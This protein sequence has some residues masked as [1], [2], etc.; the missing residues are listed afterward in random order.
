MHWEDAL[1]LSRNRGP[2]PGAQCREVL[3]DSLGI[4]VVDFRCRIP[5]HAEGPEEPNLTHSIA[6]VRRG[7]FRRSWRR[8]TL[9]ADANYVLF[10]N[11][12]EPYRYS[13]PLAGGDDCTILTIEPS[14]ALEL[15]A[16]IEPRH[17][18]RPEA[19]FRP[20]HALC[21]RRAAWLHFELLALLRNHAPRVALEDILA[22][23][24]EESL[25]S[26]YAPA[27]PTAGKGSASAQRRR[28]D[29]ADAVKLALSERLDSPPSLGELAASLGCS[30]FHLSRSF[31]D[32]VGL[33]LRRYL[34]RL[35]TSLAAARLLEDERELTSLALDLGYSDHSHFSNA[36]RKEWGTAPSRLRKRLRQGRAGADGASSP[37]AGTFGPR[38]LWPSAPFLRAAS[39][40]AAKRSTPEA[41]ESGRTA[42]KPSTMGFG[43]CPRP[44]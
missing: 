28:R 17:A 40:A 19:P 9:L 21:S 2:E 29:L 35:R 31:H 20:S 14:R 27:E 37:V 13:H 18:D 10:F 44:K 8:E 3:F 16:R 12:S 25:R 33:T 4:A 22:E 38:Q 7:G 36:F 15:V 23:L 24:A 1:P 39:I 11:A 5:A 6:F 43:G 42:P 32:S 34:G 41:I 26:A 30:P